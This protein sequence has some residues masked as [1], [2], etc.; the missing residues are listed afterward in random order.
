M[1]VSFQ[2]L[3]GLERD[4]GFQLFLCR[5]SSR[6]LVTSPGF[7]TFPIRLFSTHLQDSAPL[8]S[9]R[10]NDRWNLCGFYDF[11][12]SK[13]LAPYCLSDVLQFC[14]VL[15]QA[16]KSAIKT[17]PY[18]HAHQL[19][20]LKSY[21]K[22][23]YCLFHLHHSCK[24]LYLLDPYKILQSDLMVYNYIMHKQKNTNLQNS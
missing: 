8:V 18:F 3:Q 4:H 15:Y 2:F 14:I 22:K 7:C 11:L 23:V 9:I 13:K 21:G 17:F 16:H 1:T 24:F 12:P 5:Y 10:L 19:K 20:F 6:E